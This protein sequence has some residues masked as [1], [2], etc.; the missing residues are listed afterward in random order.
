VRGEGLWSE[1]E[2]DL[3]R[4]RLRAASLLEYEEDVLRAVQPACLPTS[5]HAYLHHLNPQLCAC[6]RACVTRTTCGTTLRH[7]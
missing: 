7:K 2:R 6:V 4:L 1:G 3:D 5:L